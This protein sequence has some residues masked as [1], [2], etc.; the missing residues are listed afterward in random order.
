M[1][2]RD[3]PSEVG[4]FLKLADRATGAG[5]IDGHEN[6]IAFVNGGA[7]GRYA[8]VRCRERVSAGV[9]DLLHQEGFT[10]EYTA[11]AA[12]KVALR[13][14]LEALAEEEGKP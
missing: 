9:Y 11:T 3:N 8:R 4:T 2:H 5:A 10:S 14:F 12:G 13:Y 6:V 1:S 7:A